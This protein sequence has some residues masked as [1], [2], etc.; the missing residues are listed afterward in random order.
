MKGFIEVEKAGVHYAIATGENEMSEAYL[1]LQLK[2]ALAELH[3]RFGML[4]VQE[5]YWEAT[6]VVKCMDHVIESMAILFDRKG[7][8]EYAKDFEQDKS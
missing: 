1:K 5:R 3:K 6:N 8:V 2:E 7:A 4:C